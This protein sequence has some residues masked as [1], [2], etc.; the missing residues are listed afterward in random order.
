MVLY[1]SQLTNVDITKSELHGTESPKDSRGL[2]KV[3]G[4]GKILN[5][6]ILSHK[7]TQADIFLF[8][9]A[10]LT[11]NSTLQL[12]K[13]MQSQQLH[14]CFHMWKPGSALEPQSPDYKNSLHYFH[15]QTST[16]RSWIAVN[17]NIK[18]CRGR[19]L[20]ITAIVVL[21]RA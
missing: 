16:K 10:T 17:T 5:C 7:K 1:F 11:V 20:Q 3:S 8:N 13:C 6:V 9:N 15:L 12:T 21:K 18:T 19:K 14:L 2:S 4:S